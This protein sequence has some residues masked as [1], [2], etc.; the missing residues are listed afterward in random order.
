MCGCSPDPTSAIEEEPDEVIN[1]Q[2]NSTSADKAHEVARS[3]NNCRSILSNNKTN[4]PVAAECISVLKDRLAP[5]EMHLE[6][7][8][9]VQEGAADEEFRKQLEDGDGI[10]DLLQYLGSREPRRSAAAEALR[11]LALRGKHN[12]IIDLLTERPD[13]GILINSLAVLMFMGTPTAQSAAVAA[14]NS[15]ASRVMVF[16][17]LRFDNA[18]EGELKGSLQAACTMSGVR[19]AVLPSGAN[20]GLR[21]AWQEARHTLS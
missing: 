8:K 5:L 1:A 11:S 16:T 2:A 20:E 21:K 19:D 12:L 6:A 17:V 4:K 18:L 13:S 7:M 14:L 15:I 3:T 10:Q 9:T